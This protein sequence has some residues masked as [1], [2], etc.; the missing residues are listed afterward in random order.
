VG[1]SV[2]IIGGGG[3]G[4]ETAIWLASRG[5]N[6][7]ILEQLPKI[8]QDVGPSTRWTRIQ[9]LQELGIKVI[10]EAKVRSVKGNEVS[11]EKDASRNTIS[12]ESIVIAVGMQPDR[13]L[14]E[15]LKGKIEVHEIGDCRKTGKAIDAIRSGFE[16]GRKI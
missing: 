15:K 10:A 13:E 3:I 8:A 2:I 6:V 7:T 12:A 9:V 11:Y 5:K 1:N 4:C 14:Y 16:V